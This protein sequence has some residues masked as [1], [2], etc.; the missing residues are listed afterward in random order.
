MLLSVLLALFGA[1]QGR[2]NEASNEMNPPEDHEEQMNR[3]LGKCD[4]VYKCETHRGVDGR[5]VHA[6]GDILDIVGAGCITR[7]TSSTFLDMMLRM[8]WKCGPCL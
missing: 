4:P 1:T 8:G 6:H 5:I 2:L 7:C 3:D